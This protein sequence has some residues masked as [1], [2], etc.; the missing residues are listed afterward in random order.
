[1]ELSC[2][3]WALTTPI[4]EAVKDIAAAGFEII[5][6]RPHTVGEEAKERNLRVSCIAV[7]QGM[8]EGVALY[9]GDEETIDRAVKYIEKA[10]VYGASL[11]AKTAYV[12]PEKGGD[13]GG[14]ERY[15]QSL[16]Q[17]ADRAEE[18]GIKLCVEHFPE[19][20]LPTV[21]STL[22]FLRAVG[23]PNLYLLFDIGH[24]QISKE[25]PAAAIQ[26]ASTQL[27]YVHLDDND[28]VG[29]LHLGLT[30]G[31]LTEDVL[32]AALNAL[33]DIGYTGEISL[34][35]NP[36][37]EDPLAALKKSRTITLAALSHLD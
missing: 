11:G 24:A 4:D 13:I 33:S 5:D 3:I 32:Q 19:T 8:P 10:L 9:S 14:L 15:A 16:M 6:V 20:A 29:D 34:E 18:L 27:G 37:L 2:C 35:L 26:A 17:L 1:M 7:S 23:H 12:V 22:G 25:D 21:A 30:D 31:I 36:Q 28:G